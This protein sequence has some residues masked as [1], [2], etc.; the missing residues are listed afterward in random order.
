MEPAAPS[1]VVETEETDT[2][3]WT[4]WP[5]F[6]AGW[7]G[8]LLPLMVVGLSVAAAAVA[9]H[10]NFGILSLL[11]LLSALWKWFVPSRYEFSSRGIVVQVF[12]HRREYD[13]QRFQRFELYPDGCLLSPFSQSHP[14]D[15]FRGLSVRFRRNRADVAVLLKRHIGE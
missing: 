9:G 11:L 15:A 7:R 4:S 5:L 12:A 14:L 3:R 8:W 10:V 6:D 2:V 1:P 13:W